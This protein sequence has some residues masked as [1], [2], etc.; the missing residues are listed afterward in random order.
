MT[1]KVL[2]ISQILNL[3]VPFKP[4][5]YFHK[6]LTFKQLQVT[7]FGSGEEY[8]Q[9]SNENQNLSARPIPE[10]VKPK[11]SSA[12]NCP[13]CARAASPM[14]RMFAEPDYTDDGPQRHAHQSNRDSCWHAMCIIAV[15]FYLGKSEY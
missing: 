15:I 13:R 6:Y 5:R 7:L 14:P 12:D 1:G 2:I 4:P 3:R 10:G 9:D 8:W 11:S